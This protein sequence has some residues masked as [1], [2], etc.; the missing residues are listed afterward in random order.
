MYDGGVMLALA[1]EAFQVS[2]ARASLA[3]PLS[4]TANVA[5]IKVRIMAIPYD[6][7]QVTRLD[8]EPSQLKNRL[9]L[10]RCSPRQ[11]AHADRTAGPDAMLLTPNLSPQLA[12]PVDDLWVI[13]KFARAVDH[14]QRF[15]NPL[16]AV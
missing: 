2:A 7:F 1:A 13:R 5:A 10:D 4:K 12:A 14:A 6:E 15:D 11:R 9:N 8:H 3:Q 16:H